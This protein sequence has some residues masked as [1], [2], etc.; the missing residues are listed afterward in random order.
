MAVP[1][2]VPLW[3][4]STETLPERH[5]QAICREEFGRKVARVEIEP[6]ADPFHASITMVGFGEASAIWVDHSLLRASRTAELVADGN[7]ALVL[8]VAGGECRATQ[9]G[10]DLSLEPGEAMLSSAADTGSFTCATDG[11]KT[12]LLSLVR[13]QLSPLIADLDAALLQRIPARTTALHLLTGYLGMFEREPILSAELA[14]LA[15]AHIYDLVAITLGAT[16]EAAEAARGRGLRAARLRAVKADI[17]AHLGDQSLS[18][19]SVAARQ[20]ISS[21]YVRKLFADEELSFSEFVL[22][23]RLA[24]ARRMLLDLRNDARTISTI[25]LDAGFADLSYFNR[26]FRSRFGATP[27]E[28][29]VEGS[30][31]PPADI[32]AGPPGPEQAPGGKPA[33]RRR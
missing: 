9:R 19:E 21:I 20:G 13:R 30:R 7:D 27:S 26:S 24:L 11:G 32:Q 3:H 22:E 23:K 17:L 25:A 10:R 16:A 6:L 12:L 18:I 33:S 5:R 29:R 28:I 1:G 4:F 8:Q 14:V 31:R 15:T 2:V